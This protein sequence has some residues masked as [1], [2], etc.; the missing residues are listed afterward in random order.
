MH[1]NTINIKQRRPSTNSVLRN[2]FYSLEPGA[3]VEVIHKDAV[4]LAG[5]LSRTT[6]RLDGTRFAVRATSTGTYRVTR[7]RAGKTPVVD[8]ARAERVSNLLEQIQ[9]L[10]QSLQQELALF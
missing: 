7:V 8:L 10:K 4:R 9:A 1:N 5:S 2:V 6:K 3:S